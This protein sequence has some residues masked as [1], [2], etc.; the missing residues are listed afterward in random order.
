MLLLD[1]ITNSLYHCRNPNLHFRDLKVKSISLYIYIISVHQS[2]LGLQ[3]TSEPPEK[4]RPE[5]KDHPTEKGKSSFMHLHDFGFQMLI[6]IGLAKGF[7]DF[8]L[9]PHVLRPWIF[10]GGLRM[11]SMVSLE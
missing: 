9:F 11:G 5:P 8:L 4:L 6:F 1:D 3:K 2:L 7:G 10:C